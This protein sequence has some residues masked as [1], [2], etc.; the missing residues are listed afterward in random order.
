MGQKANNDSM[1]RV[2]DLSLGVFLIVCMKIQKIEQSLR[3]IFHKIIYTNKNDL[4][5]MKPNEFVEVVNGVL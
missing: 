3:Q 1:K 5:L 4:Q 2:I